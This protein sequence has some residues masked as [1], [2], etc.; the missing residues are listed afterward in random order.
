MNGHSLT[1]LTRAMSMDRSNK[2][3]VMNNNGSSTSAT[4]AELDI[5]GDRARM[6]HALSPEPP[7]GG[8][9]HTA[10]PADLL[11]SAIAVDSEPRAGCSKEPG[12]SKTS[13]SEELTRKFRPEPTADS[14]LEPPVGN[15]PSG[16]GISH[17]STERKR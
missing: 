15:A 12:S 4:L 17:Q 11:P 1:R 8:K 2:P 5:A 16:V 14:G 6:P 9:D 13:I 3:F 7:L 10:D